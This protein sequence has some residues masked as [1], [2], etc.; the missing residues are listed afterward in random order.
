MTT[1]LSLLSPVTARV[2]GLLKNPKI[3]M[4]LISGASYYAGAYG[5]PLASAWVQDHAP[6]IINVLVTILGG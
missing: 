1:L 6:Q 3:Q 2:S 5:G 4:L